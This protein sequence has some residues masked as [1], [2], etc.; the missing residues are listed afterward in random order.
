MLDIT[1]YQR[2]YDE[3]SEIRQAAKSDWTIS[4]ARKREIA[5]QYKT[6]FYELRAAS[7]AAMAASKQNYTEKQ[8]QTTTE[9]ASTTA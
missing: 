2:K 8:Q 3:I 1:E 5:E 9:T 4:N 7:K 6:A